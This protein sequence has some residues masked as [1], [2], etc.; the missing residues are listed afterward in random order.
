VNDRGFFG[1]SEAANAAACSTQLRSAAWP[2]TPAGA[3]QVTGERTAG[4]VHRPRVRALEGRPGRAG[5]DSNHEVGTDHSA[6]HVAVEQECES[7]E[8]LFLLDACPA[9]H[10]APH[11]LG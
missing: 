8:H 6:E 3:V 5:A 7:A 11:A 1:G 10:H 9:R 4:E 2:S